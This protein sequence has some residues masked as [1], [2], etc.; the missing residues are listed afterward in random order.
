MFS[1]GDVNAST[2]G[3]VE[4]V[5]VN[6]LYVGIAAGSVYLA[7]AI[8]FATKRRWT[9]AAMGVASANFVFVLLNL[10]AP[11]RGVL[12]PEYRGFNVGV[13][14][15]PPGLTVTLVSG[16]IVAASL[17]SSC[18][19]LLNRPGWRMVFIAVVDSVLLITIGL[20]EVLDGLRAPDAY[21]IELGEYLQIPGVVAV[22]IIGSVFCL[23]LV[24]S[25]VWS[26]RRTGPVAEGAHG[27]SDVMGYTPPR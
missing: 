18:F 10:V 4:P 20:V 26:G 11:F 2:W 24:L 23:P 12:D 9:W 1:H 8:W 3:G 22:L 17:A 15:V 6:W 7:V 16:A 19:A 21:K 27:G 13:F 25:I 14:H 5:N